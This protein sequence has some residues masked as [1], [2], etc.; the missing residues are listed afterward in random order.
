MGAD[1]HCDDIALPGLEFVFGSGGLPILA[2]VSANTD[3]TGIG[4]SAE[5]GFR[6]PGNGNFS[7]IG[8]MPS[9]DLAEGP[10][11]APT[12]IFRSF[13]CWAGRLGFPWRRQQACTTVVALPF[14]VHEA[15]TPCGRSR[16][17]IEA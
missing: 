14:D 9:P 3:A 6:G 1:G 13:R 12:A 5:I 16:A 11:R 4:P 2:S 10:F 8:T 15:R 17:L 7:D